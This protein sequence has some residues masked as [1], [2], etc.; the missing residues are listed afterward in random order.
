MPTGNDGG[1]LQF[2]TPSESR[3][4]HEGHELTFAINDRSLRCSCEDAV[5]RLKND[6]HVESHRQCKH[7]LAFANKVWPILKPALGAR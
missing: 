5:C 7:G 4:N 3:P 1:I 6:W 2:W